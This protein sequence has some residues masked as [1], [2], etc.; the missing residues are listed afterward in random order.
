ML[1][2]QKPGARD[3]AVFD[4]IDADDIDLTDAFWEIA[5]HQFGIDDAIAHDNPADQMRKEVRLLKAQDMPGVDI[6]MAS[7]QQDIGMREYL[8][9]L[10]PA[11]HEAIN[12]F[13]IIGI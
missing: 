10:R 13:R 9:I 3:Q 6:V 12:I 8:G 5:R 2:H 4:L 7:R 11:G 1:T